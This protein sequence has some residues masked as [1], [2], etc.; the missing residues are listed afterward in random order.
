MS[1]QDVKKGAVD[2]RTFLKIMGTAGATAMVASIV[3]PSLAQAFSQTPLRSDIVPLNAESAGDLLAKLPKDLLLRAYQ[4]MVTSRKWETTFKDL[5][6]SGKDGLYGAFHPYVGEEAIANGVMT[7]LNDDD[8]IVGTHRGH[9]HVIA[10]G[11]DI[12]K[13]SAEIF[14]KATGYNKGYGGSMHITDLSKNMLGMN[15]IVGAS[16]YIGAGAAASALARKTKQ[17]AVSFAGEGAT[18]SVYFFSAIRSAALYKLPYIMVI[19]NNQYNIST[20]YREVIAVEHPAAYA[21]GLGIPVTVVDGNDVGEVYAAT[22][23]AVDRARAG[24]GP[25]VIEGFTYRWYDHSGFA[26]AKAGVDGAFGLPY[27]SD[28]EVRE[29]MAKD[30]IVR[31]KAYLVNRGVATQEQ[32]AQ[33]ESDVQKAVDASIDLARKDPDPDPKAGL[34]NVYA[35]GAV[36]ATQ[37]YNPEDPPKLTA[38]SGWSSP[39]NQYHYNA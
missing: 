15:G 29:W 31:Y 27:R 25:S 5:F 39:A 12:V 37:F 22:K 4:R 19:E 16:W 17:V 35:K 18:G 7:A 8:Y 24:N 9:G 2:R 34:L 23:A 21:Q 10:K 30:P 32:L 33:I 20:Y 1:E 11:G 13:M 28:A 38:W 26:G 14:A 6:V 36:A 3:Q